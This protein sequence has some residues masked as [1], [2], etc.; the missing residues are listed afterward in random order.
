MLLHC[1]APS[2]GDT[3]AAWLITENWTKRPTA[4][5]S[6][7]IRHGAEGEESATTSVG[8]YPKTHQTVRPKG[9]AN[10]PQITMH[11]HSNLKWDRQSLSGQVAPKA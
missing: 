7:M 11:N 8:L 9:K 10:K 2:H 6:G 1:H 4:E 5:Q 3:H